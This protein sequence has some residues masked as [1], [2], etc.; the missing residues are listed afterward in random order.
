V[1]KP[2]ALCN[3]CHLKTR[4]AHFELGGCLTCHT[5]PHTPLNI[6]F[7]GKADCL[8]CH[9][10]QSRQLAAGKSKHRALDCTVCHDFHRKLPQCTECHAPHSPEISATECKLCHKPHAPTQVAYADDIPSA[11][12]GAC[13]GT[14]LKML[15]SSKLKHKDFA[16]AFCHK[17]KHRTVPACQDC[18][19]VPHPAGIMAKFPKCG[20]CHGI[21][22]DL[23]N[24]RQL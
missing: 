22:H 14:V 9:G 2:I 4:K 19:G 8:Y 15:T 16:C 13:H 7:Q 3:K 6:V 18:H 12:C 20:E 1:K 21:A 10:S 23:N 17:E 24:G 5:N 11:Y